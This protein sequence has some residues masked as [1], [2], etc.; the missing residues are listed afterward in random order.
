M[1]RSEHFIVD[2]PPDRTWLAELGFASVDQVLKYKPE[3]FAAISGSSET[4]PVEVGPEG[5]APQRIYIKRY[6]YRGLTARLKGMFRGT[7]FGKSRARFEYDVLAEMRRRGIPAVRPIAYGERRSGGF[8]KACFLIT[9]GLTRAP[10]LDVLSARPVSDPLQGPHER[11]RLIEV[12]ARDLRN[13]HRAG[14][15][16]GGLFW[17]NILVT[18]DTDGACRSHLIDPDRK[19]RCRDGA[20]RRGDT[21]SDLADFV[22]SGIHRGQRTDL[23]RFLRAYWEVTRLRS[24][25]KMIARDILREARKRA[26]REIH[27]LAIG[28]SI[29]WLRR[30]VEKANSDSESVY[31]TESVSG[32]F[33]ALA[34]A[35]NRHKLRSVTGRA[36]FI[37]STKTDDLSDR[38]TVTLTPDDV[39]V[40]TGLAG[41]PDLS[42]ET[43]P[44]TWLA[45]VNAKQDAFERVQQHR[46]RIE[47]DTNL[48]PAIAELIDD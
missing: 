23:V 12:L 45:I 43:D 30:R 25:D 46:I 47:G 35:R 16:H 37:F 20:V 17:R 44:Q 29:D 14:V 13:M 26:A 32:F 3:T 4:F 19:G 1:S 34:C 18:R 5:G 41:R 22:S 8:L 21:V 38:Y 39:Q 27:R 31:R 24:I 42:V 2:D 7:L 6:R 15:K 36:H 33:S 40:T 10:S 48:L 28:G 11:R 9:E